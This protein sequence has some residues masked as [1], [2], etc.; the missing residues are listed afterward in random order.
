MISIWKLESD[1]WV[2]I[3]DNVEESNLLARL[4]E[5]REDGSEYRAEVR[6]ESTSSILGV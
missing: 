3:Q 5:L 1:S 6:V 2:L 4:S